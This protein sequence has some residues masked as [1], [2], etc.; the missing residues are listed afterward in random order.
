MQVKT[1]FTLRSGVQFCPNGAFFFW[2]GGI[3]IWPYWLLAG[4]N[5][6]EYPTPLEGE[7]ATPFLLLLIIATTPTQLKFP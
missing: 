1:I 3:P 2:E 4:T 6:L 7:S 5:V